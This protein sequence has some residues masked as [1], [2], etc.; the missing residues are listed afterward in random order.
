MLFV[1]QNVLSN[2]IMLHGRWADRDLVGSS[3]GLNVFSC[4]VFSLFVNSGGKRLMGRGARVFEHTHTHARARNWCSCA[5]IND[6]FFYL[7]T[8][9]HE[10]Q[11]HQQYWI[12]MSKCAYSVLGS[13]QHLIGKEVRKLQS[14][15]YY[16]CCHSVGINPLK[17]NDLKKRR[18]AQLT[19]TC[20]ILYIYSTN[21]RT[22][23]FNHAA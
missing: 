19:S 4:P 1:T 20:C 3:S 12:L 11:L 14:G 6:D 15:S 9:T 5:R 18:T 2:G 10:Y 21:I 7:M 16:H 23:Y 22:E 13:C 17:P 8:S